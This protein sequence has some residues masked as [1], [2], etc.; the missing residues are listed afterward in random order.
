MKLKEYMNTRNK[1]ITVNA[2]RSKEAKVFNLDIGNKG[3]YKQNMDV[4][5]DEITISK[6]AKSI[7][8]SSFIKNCIQD[9]LKVFLKDQNAG[10]DKQK[11]YL[12]KNEFGMLKI[13]I[14]SN[15]NKRRTDLMNSSGID[16][17]LLGVW[18]ITGSAYDVEQKLHKQFNDFRMKG[19][20]F[21]PNSFSMEDIQNLIIGK[22]LSFL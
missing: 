17:D 14:S 3:W 8:G 7:Q 11:L 5:Y 6:A 16:I 15:P 1:G 21:K 20:W 19:E 2:L 10:F 9:N 18:N 13:G 4:D 12:M 22:S